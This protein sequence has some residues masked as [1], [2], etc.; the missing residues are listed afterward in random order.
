MTTTVVI[1]WVKTSEIKPKIG[2]PI[3]V[4]G[5]GYRYAYL[6]ED[7]WKVEMTP[8]QACIWGDSS[9]YCELDIGEPE[10]WAPYPDNPYPT[11]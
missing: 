9:H 5:S 7:G 6:R 11:P 10:Y 3:I 2:E 1:H 4:P 8:D